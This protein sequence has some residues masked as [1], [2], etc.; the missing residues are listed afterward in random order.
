MLYLY[1]KCCD[2]LI[3]SLVR[4]RKLS[5]SQYSVVINLTTT[6]YCDWLSCLVRKPNDFSK[7]LKLAFIQ[8]G[9]MNLTF[10]QNDKQN[11]F[12]E[13][14]LWFF[15]SKWLKSC[16]IRTWSYPYALFKHSDQLQVPIWHNLSHLEWKKIR[17]WLRKIIWF[18]FLRNNKF[19]SPFWIKATFT[20]IL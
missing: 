18:I 17:F 11:Y 10:P 13:L 15:Y 16:H 8:K 3:S 9:L 19:T 6:L 1:L 20:R 7:V 5:Q 12:P 4:T 14:T 2:H